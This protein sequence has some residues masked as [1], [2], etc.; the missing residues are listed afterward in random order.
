[1]IYAHAWA[2]PPGAPIRGHEGEIAAMPVSAIPI[3]R[4][5]E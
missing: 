1:V 2:P 5:G 4:R 3:R